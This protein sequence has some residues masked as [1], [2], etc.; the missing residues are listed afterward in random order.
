LCVDALAAALLALEKRHETLRTT[1][2]E[3]DGMGMQVI[4]ESL[5][6][7]LKVIDIS[8]EHDVSYVE[9]LR[10]GQTAPFDLSSEPG[11]RTSLLRLGDDDHI[12]SI[13]IH[14]IVS[15]G[16]SLD[17]LRQDLGQFYAAAVRGEDPLSRVSPLPIQYR[18]FAAWQKQDEQVAEHR[19]QLEYWTEQLADSTPAELPIDR[20]RPPVLSGNAGVVQLAIE[21]SVYK[22]L[23]EFCRDRKVT[24]FV[25]LLAAFRAAHYRLTGAE[26]AT[27]GTP[28]ANRNRP[29]LEHIIGFFVNTQCMRSIVRDD[30][31][32]EE[33]VQ[34]VRATAIAA[35]ENEDVPFE[36]IVSALQPGSRDASRNPLVQIMVALHSQLDLDNIHLEGLVGEPIPTAVA[37]RFDMELHMFQ[38]EDRLSC[39]VL[40]STDLFEPETIRSMVVVFQE[41]LCRGLEEPLLPI[42][43]IPLTDG[44]A[45]LRSMGLLEVERTEYPRE[46]SVV[47]VF[48]EQVA[49]CPDATA[50]TD[51]S[52]RLTYS[53]LDQ[54]S[55]ELAGWLHDRQMAAETLVGVLAPRSCQIVVA[56][57]GILKA[58]LAYLPLDVNAPAGRIETILSAV[59]GQKLVLLGAEVS[60]RDIQLPDV[61]LVRISDTLGSHGLGYPLDAVRP[62]ATS[63]AYVMFTSGSTGKPKGVKIE[64]RGIVRLVKQSNVVSKLP[65][66]PRVA[67][68]SNIAFDASTWEMYAALLNAGTVVCI[69]YITTLDSK[70]LEGVFAREQIHSAMLTPALLKQCLA[71]TPA[72]IG[73]LDL[74]FAAGDR[75]DG[76]DATKTQALV[77]DS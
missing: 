18:D 12:L 22:S 50:V 17:V 34:Q 59:E 29:E 19:R 74:L 44:L 33:L 32:F 9:L 35:F 14:H 45:E 7:E 73:S 2:E 63:L 57:L 47:D 31:T 25:V 67:H 38:E 69:D 21:G 54:Q 48:R 52:S 61:E 6:R 58:N 37:T 11:W 13:V 41:V 43:A 10:Q 36:N 27:I 77:R 30:D 8:A 64:H 66:A 23:R 72:L 65:P 55:N 71:T 5:T 70:A 49:A 28:I 42:A 16:W 76:R 60:D 53:E 40:F 56:F 24:S 39:K 51:S 46:S 3:R 20:P 68:L 4:H 62:S 75:F 15:D 26:D 1:F